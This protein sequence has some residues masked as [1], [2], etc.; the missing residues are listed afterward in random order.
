MEYK[1]ENLLHQAIKDWPTEIGMADLLK[2]SSSP[3]RYAV[4]NLGELHDSISEIYIGKDNE[5]LYRSLHQSIFEVLHNI[6]ASVTRVRML[7]LR[8]TSVRFRFEKHLKIGAETP[9]LG[10]SEQ[11]I[12][13]V[14]RY[15]ES[16]P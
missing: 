14:K 1:F 2:N 9:E 3:D 16:N 6:A 7:D 4:V 10:Y 13:M 11:D 15:F 5:V 12:E 8:H